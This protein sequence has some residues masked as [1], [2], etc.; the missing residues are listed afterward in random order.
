MF[1]KLDLIF[2][3]IYLKEEP[4]LQLINLLYFKRY[5]KEIKLLFFKKNFSKFYCKIECNNKI[6]FTYHIIYIYINNDNYIIQIQS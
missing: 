6:K 1:L 3:I 2:I 5:N 4:I